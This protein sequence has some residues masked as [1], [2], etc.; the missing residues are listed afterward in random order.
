M[1]GFAQQTPRLQGVARA[2]FAAQET[3]HGAGLEITS[4][5]E[6]RAAFLDLVAKAIGLDL[7]FDNVFCQGFF[8]K[9]G[10]TRAAAG[11][12][13]LQNRDSDTKLARSVANRGLTKLSKRYASAIPQGRMH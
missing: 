2:V 4:A 5:G 13:V 11:F 7:G 3:G 10:R 1:L 8:P 9:N 12:K 6:R